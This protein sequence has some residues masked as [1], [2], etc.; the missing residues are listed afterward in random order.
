MVAETVINHRNGGW[1]ESV[2]DLEASGVASLYGGGEAPGST[3]VG[4][5]R[6]HGYLRLLGPP[7][8]QGGLGSPAAE[9]TGGRL[10]HPDG[11]LEGPP[12]QKETALPHGS[13]PSHLR[14]PRGVV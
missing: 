13:L 5:E 1:Q 14:W 11:A 3:N 12:G 9:P 6:A 10:S 7:Q 8:S 4:R 2:F